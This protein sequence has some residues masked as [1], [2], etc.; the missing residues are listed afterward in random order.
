MSSHKEKWI[1]QDWMGNRINR[2][3][4]PNHWVSFDDA[5]YDLDIFLGDNYETDRQEYYIIEVSH[6]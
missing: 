1:V 3:E 4:W 2:K 5:E 6:E